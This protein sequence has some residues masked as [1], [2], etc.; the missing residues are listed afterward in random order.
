[1]RT[2]HVV[3]HPQATHHVDDV[4]GG[5]Y[6][7]DLTPD[8]ERDA[9]RIAAALRDRI[10]DTADVELRTSDLRRTAQT[11]DAIGE[12]FGLTPVPDPRLRELSFGE[13]GGRPNAW[14]RECFVPPPPTGDR[15]GHT[16]GLPGAESKRHL[17]QRVY[18]AVDDLLDHHCEH[19]IVVTHGIAITFVIAAWI[20]M[21]ADSLGHVV[22]KV[23]SGSITTLHED[24]L[25]RGRM[26]TA[27]GD[28]RHLH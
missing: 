5:W 4:V 11:A 19:Q 21:P 28:T 26:V 24:D 23:T 3:T 15:M 16:G 1:M 25:Y 13:A 10:P 22:F 2:L 8:G 27:L 20:G 12:R 6:D 9:R 18:A 14:L 17:A 7:S